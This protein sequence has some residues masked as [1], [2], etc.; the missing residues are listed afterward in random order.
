MINFVKIKNES[1]Q[2][3]HFLCDFKLIVDNFCSV[4]FYDLKFSQANNQEEH[5][6]WEIV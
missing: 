5:L 4:T 3:S 1:E 2:H 6:Y